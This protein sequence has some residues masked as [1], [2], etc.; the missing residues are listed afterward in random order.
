M[1]IELTI[2]RPQTSVPLLSSRLCAK[3]NKGIG[4]WEKSPKVSYRKFVNLAARPTTDRPENMA[5]G[6]RDPKNKTKCTY[7]PMVREEASVGDIEPARTGLPTAIG[8][9]QSISSP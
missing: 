8:P 5:P 1:Q 7:N 4:H 3:V 2:Y 9:L 6:A